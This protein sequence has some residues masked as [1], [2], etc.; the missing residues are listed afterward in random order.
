MNTD[1]ENWFI[2]EQTKTE[3]NPDGER[4]EDYIVNQLARIE[5]LLITLLEQWK[6]S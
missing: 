6:K 2:P 4:I 1:I 3:T 5:H